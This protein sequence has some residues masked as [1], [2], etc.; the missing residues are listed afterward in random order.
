MGVAER[1]HTR[2]STPWLR[3]GLV[4]VAL[5]AAVALWVEPQAVVAEVRRFSAEW[6][7]L[8]L[9]S[10]RYRLCSVPGAGSLPRD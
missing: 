10:A 9:A 7:V 4:S 6:V 5:L 8:A 2:L 1:W 3:R